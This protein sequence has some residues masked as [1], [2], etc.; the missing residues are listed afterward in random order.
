MGCA[1]GALRR[2]GG[3]AATL[4]FRTVEWQHWTMLGQIK[5]CHLRAQGGSVDGVRSH[6][7]DWP[8]GQ[9]ALAEKTEAKYR[10]DSIR[11]LKSGPTL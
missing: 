3:T 8:N 9:E 1:L 2:G 6:S 5:L 11:L 4:L 10:R 7:T